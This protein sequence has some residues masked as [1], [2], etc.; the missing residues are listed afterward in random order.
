MIG[1]DAVNSTTAMMNK[2]LQIILEIIR[3]RN[4]RLRYADRSPQKDSAAPKI[5]YGEMKTA[6]YNKLL[7]TGEKMRT[8]SV[9]TDK[10]GIPHW[11]II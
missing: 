4:E 11:G 3:M 1:E 5:R 9:P 2:L 6:E 8:V 10:L 7:K